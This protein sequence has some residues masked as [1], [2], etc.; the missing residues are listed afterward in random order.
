MKHIVIVETREGGIAAVEFASVSAAS[1]WR[2]LAE[3]L[4]IETYGMLPVMNRVEALYG[5]AR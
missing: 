2:D 3:M 1:K 5:R 4:D